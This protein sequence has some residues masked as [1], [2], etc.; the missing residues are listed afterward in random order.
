[1]EWQQGLILPGIIMIKKDTVTINYP[2]SISGGSACEAYA[3]QGWGGET[4]GFPAAGYESDNICD[5]TYDY[6]NPLGLVT[7]LIFYALPFWGLFIL[8]RIYRRRQRR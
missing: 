7:E 8:V 4:F 3:G 2:Y 1:V 5:S 6:L